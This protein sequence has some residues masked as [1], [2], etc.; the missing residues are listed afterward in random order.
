MKA[1]NPYLN[2]AGNTEEA[3]RFYQ[4]VFGGELRIARFKDFPGNPMGVS[5]KDLD[6]IANV[7]LPLLND[8][9]LMGTDMLECFGQK[10]TE[11]NNFSIALEADS[12]EEAE[13]LLN[14]LADGGKVEMP[15]AKTEWAEKYGM[16]SDK[17]GVQWMVNYTGDVQFTGGQTA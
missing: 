5:D 13:K 8:S 12:A 4:S 7:A 15:L 1:V 9:M 2:F 16:C 14:A 10:L 3:F 6:K 17:F 11:G